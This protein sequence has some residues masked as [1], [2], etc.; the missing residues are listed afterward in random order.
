MR[1]IP[2]TDPAGQIVKWCGVGTDN[3]LSGPP[4]SKPANHF[5]A[6]RDGL[7]AIVT[8][9]TPPGE[10]EFANQQTLAYNAIATA[11]SARGAD[12]AGADPDIVI[13]PAFGGDRQALVMGYRRC[14]ASHRELFPRLSF[15]PL[16]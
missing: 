15:R 3:Q 16:H 8:L 10:L 2:L 6:I 4:A 5:R 1:I 14:P 11:A 13:K 9:A 12:P 7:P